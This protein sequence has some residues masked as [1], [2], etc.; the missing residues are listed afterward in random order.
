MNGRFRETEVTE[1]AT[2]GNAHNVVDEEKVDE[3]NWMSRVNLQGFVGKV[4]KEKY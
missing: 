1:R 4:A 3:S 2:R